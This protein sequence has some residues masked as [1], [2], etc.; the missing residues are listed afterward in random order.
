MKLDDL[1][2]S[3]IALAILG[4]GEYTKQLEHIHHRL[5]EINELIAG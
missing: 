2:C 1:M 5:N 4:T 3:D